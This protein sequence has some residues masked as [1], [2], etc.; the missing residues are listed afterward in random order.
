M[1]ATGSYVTL[2]KI[3][4]IYVTLEKILQTSWAGVFSA[5]SPK[6]RATGAP[7]SD[8]CEFEFQPCHLTRYVTLDM[9]L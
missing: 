9:S 8:S 3:L 7:D 4:Q 2:E 6:F 1:E 5:N